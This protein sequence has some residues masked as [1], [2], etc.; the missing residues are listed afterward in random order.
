MMLDGVHRLPDHLA[1]LGVTLEQRRGEDQPLRRSRVAVGI[2][3]ILIG[4]DM[5]I[6]L[7]VEGAHL[8][9]TLARLDAI[10]AGIHAQGAAEAARGPQP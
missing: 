9:H 1:L 4:Q 2:A 7:P 3:H 6:A 5:D 10:G 8:D